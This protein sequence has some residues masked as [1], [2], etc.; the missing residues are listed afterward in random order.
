MVAFPPF[1]TLS[2]REGYHAASLH[3]SWY[4]IKMTNLRRYLKIEKARAIVQ[5]LPQEG[6]DQSNVSATIGLFCDYLVYLLLHLF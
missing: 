6:K 2:L 3:N 1:Q 4:T 5:P